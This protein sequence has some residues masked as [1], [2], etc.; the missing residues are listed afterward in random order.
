MNDLLEWNKI[1]RLMEVHIIIF[2]SLNTGVGI[3]TENPNAPFPKIRSFHNG[4]LLMKL[5]NHERDQKITVIL[6]QDL[7]KA[8]FPS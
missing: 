7:N 8:A 6:K 2:K 1:R 3:H 4:I 5:I